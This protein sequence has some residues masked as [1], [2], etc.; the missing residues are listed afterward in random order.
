MVE[1]RRLV[2][3]SNRVPQMEAFR[4]SVEGE[5]LAALG[6]LV[7]AVQPAIRGRDALWFGWSG[8]TNGRT[9]DEP[10]TVQVG[11]TQLAT[12]SFP[13]KDWSLFY[14][15]FCNQTL[16]P[17]F[18]SFPERVSIRVDAWRAYLR[19]NRRY[20][21]VLL[22]LLKPRDILWIH[23]YHLFTL[24][25]ELRRLG[26]QGN[27]GFFLHIPFPPPEILSV[28]PWGPQLLRGLLAYDLVGVHTLQYAKNCLDALVMEL[29][30]SATDRTFTS[31][32]GTTNITA[33][34]VG[35]DPFQFRQWSQGGIQTEPRRLLQRLSPGRHIILG[36]DRLDYT[37]GVPHRLMA[38]ERLLE[39]YPNHRG[40]V[41]LV[42]VASPSR[43]NVPH[44]VQEKEQVERLVGRIN[45]R[46]ATGDWTPVHYLYRTASQTELAFLYRRAAV[47]L[48]TPLRDGMNLVAKEFVAS[49]GD[50]PGVLVL[51]RFCGAAETMLEALQVNPYDIDHTARTI[52]EALVMPTKERRRRSRA[53]LED[54]RTNTAQRWCDGFLEELEAVQHPVH[55]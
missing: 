43:T 21:Q 44:Y 9:E 38:F 49:Q 35:I 42:Q 34:P 15:L 25:S 51:S 19:V 5:N 33:R 47:C 4:Q 29:G 46:Y 20:A 40:K 36:V 53:L 3:V 23:D 17:L 18:H 26:W 16:W 7:T 12:I 55:A 30:G 11:S 54:V 27:M 13:G 24:G 39:R 8:E 22:G 31:D 52:H 28:L 48:V 41:I 2:V 37:K 32:E 14:S 6:G 1:S 50:P 10:K 45:G